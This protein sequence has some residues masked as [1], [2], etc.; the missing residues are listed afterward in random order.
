M[1]VFILSGT[2]V[3]FKIIIIIIIITITIIIINRVLLNINCIKMNFINQFLLARDL[4]PK[5]SKS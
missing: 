4:K 3:Y 2:G 5:M 1:R